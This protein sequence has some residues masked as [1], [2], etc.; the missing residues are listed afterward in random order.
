MSAG[1]ESSAA[2]QTSPFTLHIARSDGEQELSS[3]DVTLPKGLAAK[4]IGV[5]YCPEAALV[6]DTAWRP[7]AAQPFADQ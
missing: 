2:G 1:T 3:L 7:T 6:A 5:P 4:F